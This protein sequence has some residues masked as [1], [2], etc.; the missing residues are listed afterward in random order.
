MFYYE[1]NSGP[2]RKLGEYSEMLRVE[3]SWYEQVTAPARNLSFY[4]QLGPKALNDFS[5]LM[6]NSV[7]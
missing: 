6:H 2:R 1:L 4:K 7:F 5:A 3:L